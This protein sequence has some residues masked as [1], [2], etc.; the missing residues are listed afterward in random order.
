MADPS[1]ASSQAKLRKQK[2]EHAPCSASTGPCPSSNRKDKP[3]EASTAHT[4]PC[5]ADTG[6]WSTS[7]RRIH[8]NCELQLMKR[9]TR[10]DTG[11]CP[12]F[13]S[14]YK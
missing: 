2:T 1:T 12:S 10:M 14:S 6:A 9:E 8:C 5:P 11:P 7:C 3:L 13:C 4:R